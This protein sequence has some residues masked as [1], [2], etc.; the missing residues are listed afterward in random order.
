M[1]LIIRQTY[2]LA[3]HRRVANYP[4]SRPTITVPAAT[5]AMHKNTLATTYMPHVRNFPVSKSPNDS[6]AK[7]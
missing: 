3:A 4:A 5:P 2:H 6:S 1:F 7:V